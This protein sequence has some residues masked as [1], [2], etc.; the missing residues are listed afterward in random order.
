MH[1]TCL[2][3]NNII[4]L[5]QTPVPADIDAQKL[6]QQLVVRLELFGNVSDDRR[7]KLVIAASFLVP[8]VRDSERGHSRDVR[9]GR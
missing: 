3:R 5:A 7:S 9:C 1:H 6:R 8:G 2:Q 4:G